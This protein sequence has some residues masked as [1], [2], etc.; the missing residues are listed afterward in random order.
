MF[1][2]SF[3]L[4][5][6]YKIGKSWL[7]WLPSNSFYQAKTYGRYFFDL[8]FL[9]RTFTIHK[10]AGEEGGYFFNSSLPLPP[11]SQTC[12]HWPDNYCRELALYKKLTS[13]LELVHYKFNLC[14]GPLAK[15]LS[16]YHNLSVENNLK[17]I[18]TSFK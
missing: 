12:R 9:S 15:L 16:E 18:L 17:E 3:E 8:G 14:L 5:S 6:W 13:R 2:F 4:H 11:V 10:R 7:P 1:K